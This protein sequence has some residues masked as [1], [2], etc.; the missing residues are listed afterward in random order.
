MA[1]IEQLLE[2][3]FKCLENFSQR[4]LKTLLSEAPKT[5][6]Q[7]GETILKIKAADNSRF[8]VLMAGS[9]ELRQSF[10]RRQILDWNCDE[11]NDSLEALLD[12]T[13][14]IRA[15]ETTTI[16]C[17]TQQAI[18]DLFY[19]ADLYEI[20]DLKAES[21]F[22][23]EIDCIDDDYKL[24]WHSRFLQS[25]L[26]NQLSV[27]SIQT[28]FTGLEDIEVK[29]GENIVKARSEAD[30]FYIIKQGEAVIKTAEDGPFRGQQIQLA[31]GQY[32]GDEALVAETT[33]NASVSM[34]SDGVLGRLD[35]QQFE[36]IIKQ[37]LI[38]HSSLEQ[39]SQHEVIDIRFSPEFKREGQR[40]SRNIPI[41]QFR[42]M[43]EKLDK[44][45]AYIVAPANDCRSELATYLLRQAGFQAYYLNQPQ[46][47]NQSE[48]ADAS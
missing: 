48:I 44:Q 11:N 8:H 2:K 35:K 6:Y 10:E 9:V 31:E 5:E 3:P 33:R 15:M 46:A 47:A 26:A 28:L 1:S 20:V 7:A 43:M 41:P 40:S 21:D 22:L 17:I 12:G 45:K 36:A 13:G 24:D 25:A 39:E 14:T 18:E 4:D 27:S 16:L 42:L 37:Q 29:T 30:Y 32:F 34:V 23:P 19:Q 38:V